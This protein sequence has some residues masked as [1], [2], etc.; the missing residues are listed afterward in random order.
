[1]NCPQSA[2]WIHVGLA[3][4]TISVASAGYA[5]PVA[6]TERAGGVIALHGRSAAAIASQR[7]VQ[8]AQAPP[9]VDIE[10]IPLDPEPEPEP[11]PPFRAGNSHHRTV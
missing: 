1:M 11:L 7:R 6:V 9:P 2:C 3:F 10:R 5:M 8:L 4:L